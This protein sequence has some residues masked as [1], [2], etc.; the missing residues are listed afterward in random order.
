MRRFYS[1]GPVDCEEHFCV[2]RGELINQCMNQLVGNLNKGGHYFTIWAP[3]QTGKT[4][5]MRQVKDAIQN[6]YGNRFIVGTMSMQGIS[7]TEEDPIDNFLDK[8]PRL[9][10]KV[11]NFKIDT[12]KDWESYSDI[13]LKDGG[14]F[15]SP[16][17]LF[18]DEFDKL[19]PKLIDKLVN[20]FRDMYLDRDSYLLHGLALIGVR[21]VL[22]V[23]SQRGSPFNIQ[24]AMHIPNFS[25]DEVFEL[26]KQYIAESG[27]QVD[28]AVI[29]DVYEVTRGQP[30]LVCWFGELLTE[31]Y[32][33]G[34]TNTINHEIWDNVYDNAL[35]IEWNN[36]ILNLIKKAKSEYREHVYGLF[37]RA[38]VPFSMDKDWCNYLYMNG[39]IDRESVVDGRGKKLNI[40]RFSSPFVQERLY[41]ALTNDLVGDEF[42]LTALDFL[43]TLDDVFLPDSIEIPPLLRR[44]KGYLSRLKDKGLNPWKDQPRRSGLSYTEAVGHFHLYAWLQ[45]A[46][47]R[48]CVISPEFPTGN[49]KVDIHL[50]CD[51]IEAIIEVKSF[52]NLSDLESDKHQAAKYANSLGRD[53]V[54]IAAFVPSHD[55]KVHEKVSGEVLI[56]R[57]K[58]SIVTIG[59]T[60]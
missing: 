2:N 35:T 3:R 28:L 26:F 15:S 44:Y 20:Q 45:E 48:R 56:N 34:T 41:N 10:K 9:I 51:D 38:N 22:G 59:W 19:P 7:I 37:T 6:Q 21:A 39:I 4:W 53:S 40:C 42:P 8:I 46:V 60:I 27:Q 30:G 17:I 18:I 16:V 13:F 36:T 55:E 14:L 54:T 31:K 33:T 50:R 11:F 57:V 12:P 5:M 58:V 23:E 29:D 32:N 47:G 52:R 1:Y 43:D 25:N 49:G 24:R